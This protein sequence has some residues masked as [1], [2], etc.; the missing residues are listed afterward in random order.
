MKD[1]REFSQNDTW[2]SPLD[3]WGNRFLKRCFDFLFSLVFLCTLFPFILLFV[4]FV[5]ECTMPGHI[6]FVQ[7]RTGVQGK[8]FYCYKFRSMRKNKE[9]DTMQATRYDRRIT[10]WGHI[11]RKTNLDETPQ[12]FNVLIGNMSLV[13]PRPHMLKHTEIYSQLIDGYMQRHLV[14]PG[15]T[16]WSQIHGFRGETKHLV[17]MINRVKYDLW[18]IRN[19][20]FSLD[21]YII[22]K[23]VKNILGGEKNAY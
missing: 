17:T 14:K 5:T 9:A 8:T 22:A 7:K 4:L 1:L 2:H 15:I 6:F 19:W 13:G 20:R 18:Y 11:L 10:R 21:L 3:Y 12:F 23:T 16:G